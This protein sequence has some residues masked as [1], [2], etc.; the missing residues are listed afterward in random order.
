MKA[1]ARVLLVVTL[2]VVFIVGVI[3]Y[4]YDLLFKIENFKQEDQLVT[5]NSPSIEQSSAISDP[6]IT[7][8]TV[9]PSA[10][11]INGKKI[12]E[13]ATCILCHGPT[14]KADN[15]MGEAIKATNLAKG[16][17]KHNKENLPVVP[18]IAQVIAEGIPGTGMASFKAQIP[19]EKDRQDVAE[20]VHTLST[21]K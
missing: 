2:I 21:A 20:Y 7:R 8:A 14:G 1:P 15:P 3:L 9:T 17:F 16:E 18:Y 6:P 11:L 19:N 13:T 5:R 4:R 12:Y 10:Q